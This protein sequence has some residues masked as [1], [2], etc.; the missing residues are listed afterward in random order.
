MNGNKNDNSV[1]NL[2][3]CT[4]K[5]NVVHAFKNNLAFGR[6]GIQH[7]NA[8]LTDNDVRN[9]IKLLKLQKYTILEISNLIG[10]TYTMVRKIK[11]G[12]QW[13][14]IS[15]GKLNVFLPRHMNIISKEDIINNDKDV[16]KILNIS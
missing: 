4:P 2:E 6:K 14:H 11:N 12:E 9:I 16:R 15:G 3:W 1:S 5:E 13:K 8:R 7:H 10:C